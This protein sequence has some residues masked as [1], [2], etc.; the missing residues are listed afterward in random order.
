MDGQAA[1]IEALLQAIDRD[2][3]PAVRA[4]ARE[5]VQAIFDPSG[6]NLGRLTGALSAVTGHAR[7]PLTGASQTSSPATNASRS[8][9]TWG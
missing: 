3:G 2:A 5:L 7:P 8:P 6:E 4:T 1:R 9:C